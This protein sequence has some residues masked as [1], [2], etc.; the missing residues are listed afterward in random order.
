MST[1]QVLPISSSRAADGVANQNDYTALRPV[2][3]MNI[4][5]SS[6][7]FGATG[8]NHP[9]GLVQEVTWSISRKL[10]EMYQIEA[11]PNTI[12][13]PAPTIDLTDFG[14]FGLPETSYFPGEPVEVVPG[15]QEPITI[16]LKRTVMN[17]STALEA[18]INT[19]DA[20][21]YRNYDGVGG[22]PNLQVTKDGTLI[23][24]ISPLQQVRPATLYVL[25]FSPT[26]AHEV[27]YGL[28]FV[29]CWIRKVGGW[30]ITASGE[31]G[32]I[33][34]IEMLCPKVKLYQKFDGV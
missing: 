14:Q 19:S 11:I 16:N 7:R 6:V 8:A 34:E 32:I 4:L 33:E 2:G 24:G 20:A 31:G 18:I 13:E 3:A 28:Q 26:R 9:I 17:S 30:N 23:R 25:F 5:Q 21:E 22:S 1:N 27:I 29:D 10:K 12:F 15:V